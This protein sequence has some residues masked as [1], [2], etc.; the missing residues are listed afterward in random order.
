MS[1]ETKDYQSFLQYLYRIPGLAS[2]L[3]YDIQ[4]IKYNGNK[5]KS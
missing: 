4:Q 5:S 3:R 2:N 1:L